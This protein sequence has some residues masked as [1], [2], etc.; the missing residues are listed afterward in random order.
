[1][2]RKDE[3][4]SWNPFSSEPAPAV[5]YPPRGMYEIDT[6]ECYSYLGSGERG[7]AWDRDHV[8]TSLIQEY[9]RPPLEIEKIKPK[10]LKKYEQEKAGRGTPSG[11]V[12]YD[13][14]FRTDR[15]WMERTQDRKGILCLTYKLV[16]YS[17][18]VATHESR[19][20]ALKDYEQPGITWSIRSRYA[21]P[22]DVASFASVPRFSLANH[23]GVALNICTGDNKVIFP[24]RGKGMEGRGGYST[25]GE[26]MLAGRDQTV[27]A[28]TV[29]P[30]PF[31]TAVHGASR[32]LGLEIDI[33]EVRLLVVFFDTDYCQ[34]AIG[35]TV[36]T[37]TT[38]QDIRGKISHSSD[39]WEFLHTPEGKEMLVLEN[40]P[41][42]VSG[43]IAGET[44]TTWGKMTAIHAQ[45]YDHGYD[46]VK[47][48]FV[49]SGRGGIVKMITGEK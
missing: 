14:Y 21:R 6:T 11:M 40:D 46:R 49:K 36:H 15:V 32:E 19:D 39:N 45:I 10:L 48:A 44:W 4:D 3:E 27:E 7:D 23:C 18:V 26:S 47:A 16:N 34:L 8:R 2:D 22:E 37:K 30:D 24:H 42:T 41:T 17:D 5:T 20:I 33:T 9:W 13:D 1:V 28:G 29:R 35:A 31:A 25:L 12:E 38:S 43:A